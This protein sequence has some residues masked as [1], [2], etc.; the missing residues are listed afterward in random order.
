MCTTPCD[1]S[2]VISS[3]MYTWSPTLEGFRTVFRK[4]SVSLAEISWRWS[5]GAAAFL[6][7]SS[8]M[9]EYLDSLP[10]SG[11]NL[12]LLRSAHPAL[13]SHALSQI[14]RGSGAR[15]VLAASLLLIA[16]T[17]LWIFAA[18]IGRVATLNALTESIRKRAR[19]LEF[20]ASEPSLVDE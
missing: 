20:R 17:L 4:P 2:K 19:V 7:C 9:V 18:S 1:S 5:F 6:L 14:L 10:V 8:A 16:L 3:K 13:I 11:R 12:L 15:L